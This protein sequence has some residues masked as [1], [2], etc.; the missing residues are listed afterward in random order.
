[1]RL[2]VPASCS[3][4]LC[5]PPCWLKDCPGCAPCSRSGFDLYTR[6]RAASGMSSNQEP[7]ESSKD[8]AGPLAEIWDTSIPD[9]WPIL[10]PRERFL[11]HHAITSAM[12]VTRVVK[13][14]YRI[15]MSA[16]L[17]ETNAVLEYILFLAPARFN[18]RKNPLTFKMKK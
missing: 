8:K 18:V 4:C 6:P 13:A 15:S 3:I 9:R 11:A 14:P 7:K 17:Q 12:A 5:R 16:F 10:D 1:M 2:P